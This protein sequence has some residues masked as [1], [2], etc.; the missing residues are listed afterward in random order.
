VAEPVAESRCERCG[1]PFHCG[2][3]DAEPCACTTVAL[4]AATLVQLRATY[5]GCLCLRCLAELAAGG[6]VSPN[7]AAGDR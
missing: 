2:A 1:G 7:A 6:G 4:D 3:N 5:E